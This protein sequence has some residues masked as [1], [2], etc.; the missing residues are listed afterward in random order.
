ML[1]ATLVAL[2]A[3]SV[4]DDD[5]IDG[6]PTP[7]ASPEGSGPTGAGGD[8]LLASLLG[9]DPDQLVACLTPTPSSSSRE[10]PGE[11]AAAIDMI[12]DQV[13]TE[14]GLAFTDP[15]EPELLSASALA[16][17]VEAMA[18]QDLD[19]IDTDA[20][21]LTTLGLLDPDVNLQ[22]LMLDLL[23]EQV[24]GFYVPETG[25]L[26]AVARDELEPLAQVTLAHE[27]DHALVDQAIGLPDLEGEP[28]R[29]DARAASLALVEGDATLLMQRWAATHLGLLDQLAM[30][31]GAAVAP[32][33][34]LDRA[35]WLLQQQLVFPYTAG[36]S[37]VCEHYTDG[38]WDAVDA[39]YA[40]L[41]TTTAQVLWPERYERGEVAVDVDAPRLPDGWE[42]LRSDQLGAA[43]LLWLF[44]APGDDRDAAL[45]DAEQRA[46]AWAGGRML[47]AGRDGK[48]AVGI[49]LAEHDD[50]A[51][52]LCASVRTW[53]DR[54]FDDDVLTDDGT[55]TW[56]GPSQSGVLRCDEDRVRLG[57]GPDLPTAGAVIE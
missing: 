31:G 4:V 32:T 2:V 8:D 48:T 47:V 53:Y 40:D 57:I 56:S 38:G 51:T 49:V 14:R 26:T 13:A 36:L 25:E 46:R 15:V 11:P 18:L 28:G 37:F 34:N 10:L 33:T 1:V 35:P 16:E 42:Q 21:L 55:S 44:Q 39:L 45:E 52:D 7:T 22:Q 17:R 41:P 23:G 50:T 5:G 9:G 3:T 29:G 43:D 6:A 30:A 19:A 24:A 12:A 20:R 54:S 27:L